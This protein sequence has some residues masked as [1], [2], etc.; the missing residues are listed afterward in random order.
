M[1]YVSSN[2]QKKSPSR[3]YPYSAVLENF[4]ED[5]NIF[6]QFT[7]I[8]IYK[9]KTPLSPST[10]LITPHCC[11]RA[12]CSEVCSSL[13]FLLLCPHLFY[14]Y[15]DFLASHSKTEEGGGAQVTAKFPMETPNSPTVKIVA[16]S[17]IIFKA[18]LTVACMN[19]SVFRNTSLTDFSSLKQRYLLLKDKLV[20]IWGQITLENAKCSLRTYLKNNKHTFKNNYN[21]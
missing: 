20:T 19:I 16:P 9:N 5:P 14:V 7:A 4:K 11:S 6:L 8:Y 13:S 1:C 18:V 2:N 12:S 17:C 10:Y 15:H 3:L 21:A